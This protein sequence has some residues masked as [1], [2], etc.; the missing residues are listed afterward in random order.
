[1][2]DIKDA[3]YCYYETDDTIACMGSRHVNTDRA[4]FGKSEEMR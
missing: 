3:V 4:D 1:M 2:F